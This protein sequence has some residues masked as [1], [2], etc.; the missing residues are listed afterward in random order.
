MATR[1]ALA[2]QKATMTV[3]RRPRMSR[4][5]LCRPCVAFACDRRFLDARSLCWSCAVG[6]LRHPTQ[7]D[8]GFYQGRLNVDVNPHR[9]SAEGDANI[10]GEASQT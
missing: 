5:L 4:G 3:P 9:P 7:R 10:A 8:A 2:P 1:V 6:G